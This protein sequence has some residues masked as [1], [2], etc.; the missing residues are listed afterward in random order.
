AAGSSLAI[1]AVRIAA[2]CADPAAA[3][4]RSG[5]ALLAVVCCIGQIPGAVFGADGH[6]RGSNITCGPH[7]ARRTNA[8]GAAGHGRA[9]HKHAG[10]KCRAGWDYDLDHVADRD[11]GGRRTV[12]AADLG[13]ALA[14]AS[15]AGSGRTSA[16][17]IS[18]IAGTD[19]I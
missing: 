1:Y 2:G 13:Y 5:R 14:Q 10:R 6:R 17:D 9:F 8:G 19:L 15:R 4:S 16:G 7:A 3:S 12:G 18:T 11:M